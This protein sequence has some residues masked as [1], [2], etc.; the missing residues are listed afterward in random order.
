MGE[1]LIKY[2][3]RQFEGSGFEAV[4]ACPMCDF[5]Y[6]HIEKVTVLGDQDCGP[7]KE[8]IEINNGDN[9]L[10]ARKFLSHHHMA[11]GT[12]GRGLETLIEMKCESSHVWQIVLSFHKGNSSL[13]TRFIRHEPIAA[14]DPTTSNAPDPLA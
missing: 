7:M 10:K 9:G 13:W 6:N 2:W 3:E 11:P 8:Y 1:N 4:L 5:E 12:R 14:G